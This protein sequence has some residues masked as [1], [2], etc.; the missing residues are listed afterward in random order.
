MTHEIKQQSQD[1]SFRYYSLGAIISLVCCAV[2]IAF[3]F[4]RGALILNLS[5]ANTAEFHDLSFADNAPAYKDRDKSQK[6]TS[7]D[8]V[9]I[10]APVLQEFTELN[11]VIGNAKNPTKA[12]RHDT[13]LVQPAPKPLHFTLRKNAKIQVVTLKSPRSWNLTPPV[14][15]LPYG[16]KLSTQAQEYIRE[17]S[18]TQYMYTID[19]EGQRLTLPL[20]NAE[21]KI[22]VVGDSVPFGVG[23]ND[24]DTMPSHLQRFLPDVKVINGGVGGYSSS[25]VLAAL[26]TRLEEEKYESLVYLV[27]QN[28]FWTFNDSPEWSTP[29]NTEDSLELINTTFAALADKTDRFKSIVIIFN[30]YLEYLIPDLLGPAGWSQQRMEHTKVIEEAVQQACTRYGFPFIKANDLILKAS[31]KQQSIFSIPAFF[32]DHSHYSSEGNAIL[33][34]ETARALEKSIGTDQP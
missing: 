17:Q 11:A 1:A 27:C 21:R 32:V 15:H 22:L 25:Q 5:G 8:L 34:E 10:P 29:K 16:A 13:L 24:D 20:S 30:T 28:D 18:R 33:A 23:V 7:S 9:T 12:K 4:W 26:D 14:L 6:L 19:A 31:Q 2:I 3:A